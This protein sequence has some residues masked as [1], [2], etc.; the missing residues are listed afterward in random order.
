[1]RS[2]GG[3][4][5]GSCKG[6]RQKQACTQKREEEPD[7]PAEAEPK[8][9]R[10]GKAQ[11]KFDKKSAHFTRHLKRALTKDDGEERS[12]PKVYRR[13]S[14]LPQ[15]DSINN[16]ASIV[17]SSTALELRGSSGRPSRADVR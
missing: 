1:M 4:A 11:Y 9:V 14:S 12:G 13:D 15:V 8:E 6:C 2:K 5:C 7:Q 17:S 16:G 3:R 10:K